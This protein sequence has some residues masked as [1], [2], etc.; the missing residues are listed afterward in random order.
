MKLPRTAVVAAAVALTLTTVALGGDSSARS[1][2]I[3]Y[4]GV[5]C[6]TKG[7]SVG[8]SISG[9]GTSD[10]SFRMNRYMI[11]VMLKGKTVFKQKEPVVAKNVNF[12]PGWPG[13]VFM[14]VGCMPSSQFKGIVCVPVTKSG[15]D[16]AAALSKTHVEVGGSTGE[17]AFAQLQPKGTTTKPPPPT[18]TVTTTTTVTVTTTPTTTTTAHAI[19]HFYGNGNLDLQPFSIPVGETLTWTS[20]WPDGAAIGDPNGDIGIW[21]NLG[22]GNAATLV[23]VTNVA[24][25]SISLPAGTH[26][27]SIVDEGS[28]TIDIS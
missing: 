4:R 16:F 18:T 23:S 9:K 21:D 13:K 19:Y 12:V 3:N 2:T 8:C 24:S 5:H 7:Y 6:L 28:W 10:Y 11:V 20:T 26:Q 27:L 17:A 14:G 22:T 15:R 1:W 25:G